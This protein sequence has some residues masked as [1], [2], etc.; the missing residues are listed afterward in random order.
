MTIVHL[1]FNS[2]VD[3]IWLWRWS[4][5]QQVIRGTFSAA[6]RLLKERKEFTFFASSASFYKLVE[7]TD[8]RLFAD[9]KALVK[10]GRW[11]IVGGWW[12]APD[13]RCDLQAIEVSGN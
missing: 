3:P 8:P 5:G 9:I 12:V 13:Y 4:E 1:V 2:H 10:E 7:E 11:G 6:V